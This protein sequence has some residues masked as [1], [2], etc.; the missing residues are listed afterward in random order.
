MKKQEIIDQLQDYPN[1]EAVENF[2][3]YC[4]RV[5]YEIKKGTTE[6]KNWWFKE[7]TVQEVCELFCRVS[8]DGLIFD[9]KHITFISTGISYDYI[10]YKNKMF[11][12]YPETKIDID[13]VY[14]GDK[15]NFSKESGTVIYNH[16]MKDPFKQK[17]ANIIGGYVVIKNSRGEFLTRLS[18]DDFKKHRKIAKTDSIWKEWYPEMCRKTLIKK[19]CGAHFQDLYKGIEEIDNENYDLDK[20]DEKTPLEI[21]RAEIIEALDVYQGDDK[22]KIQSLCRT[23]SDA[24]EFNIE[25]ANSILKQIT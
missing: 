3:A 17:D 1:K 9:G 7:K 2:A 14:K 15:F 23:K 5:R 24:K 21:K 18:N 25:F 6:L 22:E 13:L 16:E 10:A 8:A 4:I 12:C 19:A 11:L 20:L